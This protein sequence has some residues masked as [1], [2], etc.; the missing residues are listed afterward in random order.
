MKSLPISL[1][2]LLGH[3]LTAQTLPD[4]ERLEVR[5]ARLF[6]LDNNSVRR[7]VLQGERASRGTD[8]RIHIEKATLVV[9]SGDDSF[10]LKSD[11]F[12]YRPNTNEFSCPG[13]VEAD[14]P[15]GGTMSLPPGSGE[16]HFGDV[17]RFNM[18]CV[19]DATLNRGDDS[20]SATM[21]DPTVA[22]TVKKTL[23]DD[24]DALSLDSF[25]IRGRRG[26]TMSV[27]LDQVPSLEGDRLESAIVDLV[28]Y[29]DASLELAQGGEEAT[30]RMLRRASMTVRE[31]DQP[32]VVTSESIE[33]SGDLERSGSSATL[34]GVRMAARRNVLLHG[35][36]VHGRGGQL[37]YQQLPG[38]SEM[39]L[40][41][42]PDLTLA[43][44]SDAQG[45]PIS[46]NLRADDYVNVLVR[47]S[48]GNDTPQSARIELSG[49][50]TVRRLRADHA[51]WQVVGT[52]VRLF[53]WKD[54]PE[55]FSHS[56]DVVA[57]GFSPLLSL[58]GGA[59]PDEGGARVSR[60]SVI[61]TRAEGTLIGDRTD[62]RVDGP[63]AMAVVY[64]D[65]PLA[66]VIRSALG[67]A[68]QPDAGGRPGRLTV[69]AASTL[70]LGLTGAGSDLEVA[71]R[72][73]VSLVYYP[74]PRDDSGM[75]SLSGAF[76][77]LALAGRTLRSAD[78]VATNRAQA[79]ATLGYDLLVA[80]SLHLRGDESQLVTAIEGPGRM[81]VRDPNSIQYFLRALSNL[82]QRGRP[83]DSRQTP[84]AGWLEFNG[85]CRV[86]SRVLPAGGESRS[87]EIAGP[88]AHLVY[89]DF[90]KP[91]AGASAVND[92]AELELP[93][94]Q[95][96]Y[97]MKGRRAWL[98]SQRSRS[99]APAINVLRLE[100]DA[101]VRSTMD[102]L[103]ANATEALELT[104]AEESSSERNPFTAVLLGQS[105]LRIGRAGEF[106]G[107]YVRSGVFAYDGLWQLH[108]GDR[109]ELSQR[110]LDA[111]VGGHSLGD[112]R[113]LLDAALKA[114]TAD[115]RNRHAVAARDMLAR[116]TGDA[117]VPLESLPA[118]LAQPRRA[119]DL[120]SIAVQA[121]GEQPSVELHD[122]R[123]LLSSLLDVAGGGG[124]TGVFHSTRRGTPPMH[125]EMR[126]A[127]AT[128]NGLGD[129]VDIIATG[130]ITLTRAEYSLTGSRLTRDPDGSLL[131]DDSRIVLPAALGVTVE[132]VR[133]TSLQPAGKRGLVTRISGTGMKVKI[134]VE[135]GQ[136]R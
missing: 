52:I 126:D 46:M 109:L 101:V 13:G 6:I 81:V 108:A 53:S 56:F 96:L 39:R 32:F 78:L 135:G 73:D 115:E 112:V 66:E 18:T 110:P 117:G 12:T 14:L 55:S 49:R 116:L 127:V 60:A 42:Y 3:A 106:F 77:G 97:F 20:F 83:A 7:A 118:E 64:A 28:C 99:D 130:P 123:R 41:Q 133:Q 36:G 86:V 107:E 131:L 63:N 125:L 128:F 85:D 29:G 121:Q 4:I 120:L 37:D 59:I 111:R 74:L 98:H 84:D 24:K 75:V 94:V 35:R 57:I 119:L 95:Q 132:G 26:A 21:K 79:V 40:A 43:R 45:Q 122:A 31:G 129:V 27:Q 19:G 51:D 34:S 88:V 65:F 38:H 91:R 9:R 10:T 71:A 90:E 93:E 72:G 69:N 11:E 47:N 30:L 113:K 124:V 67:M 48:A 22:L 114:E 1:L 70:A 16:I 23:G 103:Y 50:A 89:G 15:G 82:P 134:R 136:R 54:S 102:D 76:V 68:P 87:L 104:G 105:E 44:G 5:N 62:V 8:G 33:L 2:L 80:G 61:G 100:G 58:L 92:L 17:V 25:D